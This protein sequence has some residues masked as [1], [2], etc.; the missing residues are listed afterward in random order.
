M[1]RVRKYSGDDPDVT[2]GML[3]FARVEK[4][5]GSDPAEPR[6]VIEGGSGVGRVTRPGLEQ[7]IGQ[8]AI[9]QVPPPDDPGRV[10]WKCVSNTDT[11]ET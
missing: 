5:G 3:V 6:V 9:N 7:A 1:R 11:A 10:F 4:T 2:G 8:A